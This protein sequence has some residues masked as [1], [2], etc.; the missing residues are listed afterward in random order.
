M[1]EV[2]ALQLRQ[3]L[4]KVISR[5]MRTGEPVLLKKGREPVGVL[6][7]LK[8]FEE[9]FV[10]K[11]AHERRLGIMD[12]IEALARDSSDDVSSAQALRELR[13]A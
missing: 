9:R 10:D 3:S 8:D 6:I 11:A 12:A 1:R 5:L 4:G 7:S 2:T 13:D